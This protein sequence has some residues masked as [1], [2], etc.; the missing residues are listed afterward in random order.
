MLFDVL[1]L[2]EGARGFDLLVDV[3]AVDYL[4]YPDAVDRFG[5][6]YVLLNIDDATSG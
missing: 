2:A 1:E 6:V 4:D 5:V 3:T